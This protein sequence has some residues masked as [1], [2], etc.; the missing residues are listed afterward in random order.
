MSSFLPGSELS[1]SFGAVAAQYDAARPGYPD[2]LF[3][4]VERLS[5]RPLRGARV[6]D[7]GAGT[8]IV[9]RL[10]RGRGA[11]VVAVEPTPGMAEQLRRVSPEIP[12]VRGDGDR[13]PFADGSADFVTY[14]QAFHWTTPARS[15][16]EARRVLRP[17]GALAV[18]W[19]VKDRTQGWPR[20][21]EQ[22]LIAACPQYHGYGAVNDSAPE[23]ER[24][25]LSV[26]RAVLRWSR[27]IPVEQ[28]LA[29]LG[30]RSYVAVLD[31]SRREQVLTAERAALLRV[32]PDGVVVEDFDLDVTVGVAA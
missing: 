2:E 15:V 5:G 30:S 20:E 17:G 24:L 26:R 32:F 11:D 28:A 7:V 23:L 21:Q 27:S 25:G 9:T 16:P 3:T 6:L 29:D 22:R 18:F 13:L 14:G 4:A 1:S 31:A 12:L 19:N 8:G 10:L